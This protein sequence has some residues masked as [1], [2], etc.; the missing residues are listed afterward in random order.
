M[1]ITGNVALCLPD[2]VPLLLSLLSRGLLPELPLL[3]SKNRVHDAARG[4]WQGAEGSTNAYVS[5]TSLAFYC[6]SCSVLSTVPLRNG[7]WTIMDIHL[8]PPS[9]PPIMIIG[10]S[11]GLKHC[12]VAI[13]IRSRGLR[14]GPQYCAR[15]YLPGD[16]PPF[17]AGR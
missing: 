15:A 9:P 8:P 1:S 10:S 6:L 3:H 5:L 17:T 12:S 2:V 7:S 13:G 16:S 14:G 11:Q 4:A